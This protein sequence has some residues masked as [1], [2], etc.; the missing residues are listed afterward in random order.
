MTDN[1]VKYTAELTLQSFNSL[2]FPQTQRYCDSN[3]KT[4]KK[5]NVE[6]VNSFIIAMYFTLNGYQR[7]FLKDPLHPQF[8]RTDAVNH[9]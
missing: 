2:N 8:E 1:S 6:K 9:C 5:Y 3:I 4:S 7:L